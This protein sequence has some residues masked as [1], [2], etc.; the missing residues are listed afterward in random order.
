MA[1]YY[2]RLKKRNVPLS[3]L[4]SDENCFISWQRSVVQEVNDWG[5]AK[6]FWFNCSFLFIYIKYRWVMCEW[7]FLSKKGQLEEEDDGQVDF[8]M[9]MKSVTWIMICLNVKYLDWICELVINFINLQLFTEKWTNT[10]KL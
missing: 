2:Q 9:I 10:E 4:L 3:H 6:I 8:W 7:I 5:P 1:Y